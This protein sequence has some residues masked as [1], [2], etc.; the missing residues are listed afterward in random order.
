MDLK[1]N[2]SKG[3]LDYLGKKDGVY[4]IKRIKVFHGKINTYKDLRD[5]SNEIKIKFNEI[6]YQ[7][8]W[9]EMSRQTIKQKSNC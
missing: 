9:I 8:T 5:R 6:V 1:I 4:E 3:W 2:R 7:I